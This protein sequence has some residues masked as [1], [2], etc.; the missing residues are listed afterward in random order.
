M[1]D[2]WLRSLTPQ[3]EEVEW[4][5]ERTEG[6]ALRLYPS[7]RRAWHLRYRLP[8]GRQRRISLGAYPAVSLEAAR[9]LAAA[10]RGKLAK[11]EDPRRERDAVSNVETF[12]ALVELYLKRAKRALRERTW[13]E[14][15]RLLRGRDLGP[16]AHVSLAEIRRPQIA[17]ILERILERGSPVS[18]NRT[19]AA[20]SACMA[21]AVELDLLDHNPVAG[22]RRPGT[23]ASRGRV[24]SAGEIRALWAVWERLGT[25]TAAGLRLVLLTAQRPGEVFR[26][27]WADLAGN[28][29]EI[30]AAVA[31]NKRAH[32]VHLSETAKAVLA[33]I[34]RGDSPWVF[35]ADSREGRVTWINKSARHHGDLASVTGWTPHDL[36][37]TAATGMADLG[38]SDAVVSRVLNHAGRGV[39]QR[40][41]ISGAHTRE[42][43]EA[44]DRWGS[45]VA[46]LTARGDSRPIAEAPTPTSRRSSR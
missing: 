39:T 32:S 25:S 33:E 36:R 4:V 29:W 17:A 46:D 1:T 40:V 13:Q 37:R 38:V 27:R 2:R 7:G 41:Y 44:W 15:E 12:G 23:E 43:V 20:L 45:H 10:E 42:M 14:N 18:A 21:Y 3:A 28:S 34:H 5:D 8:S 31:K 24:L 6:L 16:L 19:R 35:G 11:G 26:M 9:D 30:P 22:T